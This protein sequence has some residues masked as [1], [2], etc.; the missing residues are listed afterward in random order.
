MISV[1]PAK[2]WQRGR[3]REVFR[4]VRAAALHARHRCCCR[5]YRR[6]GI[7]ER[8][9]RA[10]RHAARINVCREGVPRAPARLNTHKTLQYAV[11]LRKAAQS[12]KSAAPVQEAT[13][14][15]HSQPT[16]PIRQRPPVPLPD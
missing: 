15:M 12:A 16:M 9:Y 4:Q 5:P 7:E 11:A 1:A 6:G 8:N 2:K 14:L 10:P 13:M 3:A